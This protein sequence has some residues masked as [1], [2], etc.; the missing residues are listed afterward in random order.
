MTRILLAIALTVAALAGTPAHAV[1][2][3]EILS[4]PRLE[5]R[6]RVISKDLR[7]VVCQNQSIDDSNADIA[8][9]MRLLV[10]ERL[11][12]GDADQQVVDYLVARYGEYV[13]LNP[14]F[15]AA[16]L[17]LWIGPPVMV[18]IIGAIIFMA[19]RA[20]QH[21]A[22]V[23]VPDPF[24]AADRRRLDALVSDLERKIDADAAAADNSDAPKPT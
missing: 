23:G 20:Q 10:R 11:V 15:R 17:G 8:R 5:A 22:P 13:L 1:E 14:P 9:D 3:D 18:V 19:F 7:C 16:T 21:H 24:S 6:A 2:P 12:A 4:D